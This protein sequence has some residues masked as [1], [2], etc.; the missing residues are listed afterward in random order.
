MLKLAI[1]QSEADQIRHRLIPADAIQGMAT[2]VEDLR[3]EVAEILQEEKEEKAIRQ[4]EMEVK[5]GSNMVEH[6]EEIFGRPRREWFQS[7]K[8]KQ[9]AKSEYGSA[10]AIYYSG[11]FTLTL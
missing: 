6:E 8:D 10:I 7:E 9:A 1:R 4:A 5:K 2:R 3:D 11:M